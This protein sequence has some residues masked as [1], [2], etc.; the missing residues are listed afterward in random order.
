MRGVCVNVRYEID[1]FNKL[2]VKGGGKSGVPEFRH[3]LDGI[4]KMAPGNTLDFDAS[5]VVDVSGHVVRNG[6]RNI[7]SV[8]MPSA[9]HATQRSSRLR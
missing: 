7:E 9:G 4:F 3:V 2:I 6:I 5:N 1:P 8:A